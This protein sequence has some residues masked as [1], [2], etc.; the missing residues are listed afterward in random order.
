MKLHRI[1]TKRPVD[2]WLVNFSALSQ[3]ASDPRDFVPSGPP[4]TEWFNNSRAYYG[5]TITYQGYAGLNRTYLDD[6]T[7]DL[8]YMFETDLPFND[9]VTE[10]LKKTTD[11]SDP[12]V[13][14]FMRQISNSGVS[15]NVQFKIED[16][17][18]IITDYLPPGDMVD[19]IR[20]WPIRS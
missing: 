9:F 8:I 13:S 12:V 2:P 18:G 16:D 20:L 3:I 17:E 15:Y 14:E 19:R 10:Y 11:L 1:L 6:N 4:S 5:L 7:L